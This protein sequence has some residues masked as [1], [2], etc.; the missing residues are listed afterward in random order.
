MGARKGLFPGMLESRTFRIVLVSE[1]HGGGVESTA[2]PDQTIQYSG[3]EVSVT[4]K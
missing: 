4:E 1:N 2:S 3:R